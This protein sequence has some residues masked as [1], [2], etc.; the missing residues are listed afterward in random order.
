MEASQAELLKN[1]TLVTRKF[2]QLSQR[3]TEV[4]EQ[5]TMA[6]TLPSENLIDHIATS[7]QSFN[8]LRDQALELVCLLASSTARTPKSDRSHVVL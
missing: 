6:G 1:F 2:E 8:E 4:A 3:L 5:A 7:R